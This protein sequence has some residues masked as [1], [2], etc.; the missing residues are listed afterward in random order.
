MQNM[1]MKVSPTTA[2][3]KPYSLK[4][5]DIKTCID[6]LMQHYR[7]SDATPGDVPGGGH[8]MHN[9]YASGELSSGLQYQRAT[10][11]STPLRNCAEAPEALAE[12]GEDGI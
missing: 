6:E 12:L 11:H 9:E 3:K 8:K 1:G 10:S 5:T 7:Q 4:H 2:V